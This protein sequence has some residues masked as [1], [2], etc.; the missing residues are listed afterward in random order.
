MV[1]AVAIVKFGSTSTT[2]LAAVG[3]NRVILREQRLINLFSPDGPERI[4]AWAREIRNRVDQL[5]IEPLAAGGEGL[6]LN[7]PLQSRLERVF[8]WWWHLTGATEGILAWMAVKAQHPACDVV[9]D[10]GGGSTEIITREKTL[11]YPVGAARSGSAAWEVFTDA[12]GPVFIGGTA[13]A[14]AARMKRWQLTADHVA[15]FLQALKTHPEQFRDLDPLRRQMLPRGLA[16]MED[17]IRRNEWPQFDVSDRG[18]TEGLWLAA[19][20]GRIAP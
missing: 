7:R 2:L 1:G 4:V 10:I 14:L 8:P 13:V 16:L 15:G 5:G 18:L 20:L 9:V 6:R 12:R 19:S 17:I 11:S 3:L